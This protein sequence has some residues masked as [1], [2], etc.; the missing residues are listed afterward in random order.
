MTDPIRV[1]L[2]DDQKLFRGGL[3]VI[4]D[5]QDGMEVVGEPTTAGSR[6]AWSTGSTPTSY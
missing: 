2:A 4:V 5:A 6:S 1:L 3:R